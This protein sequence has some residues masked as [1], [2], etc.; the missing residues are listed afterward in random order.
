M[1]S[2]KYTVEGALERGITQGME[3]G[4]RKKEQSVVLNMLKKKMDLNIIVECTGVSKEQVL[5][6]QKQADL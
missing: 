4:L 3:K 6:L 5:E 1:E 2:L